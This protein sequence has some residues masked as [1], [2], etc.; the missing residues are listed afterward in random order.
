MVNDSLWCAYERGDV[1]KTGWGYYS[2]ELA[3]AALPLPCGHNEGQQPAVGVRVSK[4]GRNGGEA[5]LRA[6]ISVYESG[7][8]NSRSGK[9]TPCGDTW[10][11]AAALIAK[12]T[13]NATWAGRA[14]VK[15][16]GFTL[17]LTNGRTSPATAAQ[18]TR[19][20]QRDNSGTGAAGLLAGPFR[21][22][23]RCCVRLATRRHGMQGGW[24]RSSG[25]WIAGCRQ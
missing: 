4:R 22:R 21:V 10:A 12:H 11:L 24:R 8:F 9:Y 17:P 7:T 14:T 25:R 19:T 2:S 23:T 16:E 15:L 6:A 13:K 5:Y 20:V 18:P 1:A 3:L